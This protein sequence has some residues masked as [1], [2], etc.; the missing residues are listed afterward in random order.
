[1]FSPRLR[2]PKGHERSYGSCKMNPKL[3]CTAQWTNVNIIQMNTLW[4]IILYDWKLYRYMYYDWT[5]L[6]SNYSIQTLIMAVYIT[7]AVSHIECT[8]CKLAGLGHWTHH[9]STQCCQPTF[10][11]Y[12]LTVSLVKRLSQNFKHILILK[13]Y[14]VLCIIQ[15]NMTKQQIQVKINTPN[16]LG[17]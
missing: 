12:Y 2:P 3:F 9:T 17:L 14:N 5:L 8:Y 6:M 10:T 15:N 13:I 7:I 16:T 11:I 1:M 4:M